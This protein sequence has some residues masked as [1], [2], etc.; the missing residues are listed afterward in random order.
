MKHQR[1]GSRRFEASSL[2]DWSCPFKKVGSVS[3]RRGWSA[4]VSRSKDSPRSR[5]PRRSTGLDD[6]FAANPIG[7]PPMRE[8]NVRL[9]GQ[10]VRF[11]AIGFALILMILT[12]VPATE[13]PET[14]LQHDV[15][16]F[17]AF[18]LL[19]LLIAFG[20]R[21]EARS[22][23][24]GSIVFAAFIEGTQIPLQTRHARLEDFLVDAAGLCL[25]ILIARLVSRSYLRLS[26]TKDGV[27][28]PVE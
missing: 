12:I 13:R 15:E 28:A 25:G 8:R 3:S 17:G 27:R 16:H 20:F 22:M 26:L 21:A 7:V 6:Q 10:F 11:S 9:L 4:M 19:G 18:S 1:A 14:G 24:L 5:V 2:V 23:L